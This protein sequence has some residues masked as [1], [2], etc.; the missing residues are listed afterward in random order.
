[1]NKLLVVLMSSLI[2]LSFSTNSV[3]ADRDNSRNIDQ[4]TQEAEQRKTTT[5]ARE[6]AQETTRISEERRVSEERKQTKVRYNN[7]SREA[8]QQEGVASEW[9][10]ITQR[11]TNMSS[12]DRN[13][14]HNS[15]AKY[16]SESTGIALGIKAGFPLLER[17]N[18]LSIEDFPGIALPKSIERLLEE[19][20]NLDSEEQPVNE[21][22]GSEEI[23][24][25]G[26]EKEV[27]ESLEVEQGVKDPE[28]EQ[29]IEGSKEYKEKKEAWYKIVQTHN[30]MLWGIKD[31]KQE[32]LEYLREKKE[33][34]SAYIEAKAILDSAMEVYGTNFSLAEDVYLEML[35]PY[36]NTFKT[37][38]LIAEQQRDL[39]LD[40]ANLYT[41]EKKQQMID[42]AWA[43]FWGAWNSAEEI[44]EQ[45]K[46]SLVA[47]KKEM[48]SQAWQTYGPTIMDADANLKVVEIQILTSMAD[49][50]DAV[51]DNYD[52]QLVARKQWLQ[53]A[54]TVFEEQ[55]GPTEWG[56]V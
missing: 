48:Q 20:G 46:E 7:D 37:A 32:A 15:H 31:D 50:Y 19:Q 16:K 41:G 10:E 24:K 22:K 8:E 29:A 2:A 40:E 27:E 43:A 26:E 34:H 23:L 53:E 5:K 25:T 51:Y 18:R 49:E 1:M 44:Y 9:R 30:S 17:L 11:L 33:G 54:I 6:A 12:E 13:S 36:Y 38:K 55:Y 35:T 47:L 56:G 42:M 21:E 3:S 45:V 14:M 4:N 39:A 28:I 52:A